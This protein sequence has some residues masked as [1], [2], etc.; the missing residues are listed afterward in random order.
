MTTIIKD[1]STTH[2]TR[3]SFLFQK[4]IKLDGPLVDF[5]NS[6]SQEISQK[7]MGTNLTKNKKKF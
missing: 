4:Y 5:K 7:N 3:K 2:T 6:P 1:H